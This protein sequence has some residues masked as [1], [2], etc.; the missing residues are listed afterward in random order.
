MFLRLDSDNMRKKNGYTAVDI[1][2][3]IVTLGLVTLFTVPKLSHAFENNKDTLYNESL[4]LYLNQATRY[5]NTIKDEVKE[6]NSYIVSIK[7]LVDKGYIGSTNGDVTDIRDGSSMLNI[8]IH[9]IYD[10]EKDEVY[11]EVV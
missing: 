2:L 1:L 11:A 4:E 7:D 8:K 5:G 6:N 9:L 3:I 10:E